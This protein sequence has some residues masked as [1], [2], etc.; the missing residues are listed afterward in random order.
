MLKNTV[1]SIIFAGSLLIAGMATAMSA[2]HGLFVGFDGGMSKVDVSRSALQSLGFDPHKIAAINDSGAAFGVHVG[3]MFNRYIGLQLY[4]NK[5]NM[6]KIDAPTLS[7]VGTTPVYRISPYNAL[8]GFLFSVPIKDNFALYGQVGLGNTWLHTKDDIHNT[9]KTHFTQE[10]QGGLGLAYQVDRHI[11]LS[12][13]FNHARIKATLASKH[14][15][16]DLNYYNVAFT[17][18]F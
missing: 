18:I 4:L 10:P 15:K 11:I 8:L 6:I 17:Y 9:T 5:Y 13:G 14:K 16:F 2:I 3:W 12:T 1:R 7:G